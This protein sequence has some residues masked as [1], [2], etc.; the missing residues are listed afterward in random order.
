[1]EI[2]ATQKKPIFSLIIPMKNADRYIRN[3]LDSI[4]EQEFEDIQVIVVDDNSD[5]TDISQYR[6]N[7]WKKQH[8]NI[9]LQLFKTSKEQGGPGGARNIGI[10]NA[11]GEYI[12]FLDA[13]D[14]L[15]Q[16]A[17]CSIK[18]TI[19][20]NPT[21]DIFVLGSQL[22]RCDK[23]DNAIATLKA[24]SGKISESRFFQIGVNT[25]GTIWNQCIR[26]SLF[27]EKDDKYKIR[28]KPNCKF[29]DLPAKVSLFVRN[30]KDIKAVPKITH[31]QF[32]RPNTSITGTLSL[33]D[34]HRLREAHYEIANIKNS[35]TNLSPKDK[36]YID[37][38]KVSFIIVAAWLVQKALRNKL[39]RYR[40]RKLEEKQMLADQ[41]RLER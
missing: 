16:G 23:Y 30:K 8:P 31:T 34:M 12:L 29:E 9:D 41:E 3:T 2:G 21:T 32:S 19:D 26:K 28:F 6:V 15:N 24:P 25:A 27:G 33:K 14:E 36:I 37:A 38:R 7:E 10:D 1:M 40:M 4:A 22:I 35:E 11:I 13:D 39:D 5:S 18:K 20:E 17:L